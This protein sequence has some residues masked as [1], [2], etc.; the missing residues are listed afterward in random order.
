[1]ISPQKSGLRDSLE[2]CSIDPMDT[3]STL[4]A[5]HTLIT[6]A[7]GV[8]VMDTAA[9][10]RSQYYFTLQGISDLDAQ[11][12]DLICVACRMPLDWWQW[13][14]SRGYSRDTNCDCGEPVTRRF[15]RK[16]PSHQRFAVESPGYFDRVWY[17]ASHNRNWI[18][19]VQGAED[20]ELLVHAGSKLAALSRADDLGRGHLFG[21]RKPIY[22]HSF[23]LSDPSAIST[24][25]YDDLMDEWPVRLDDE[26]PMPLCPI[27]DEEERSDS[28]SWQPL[29]YGVQGAP[30][31][32]RYEIPGEISLILHAGLIN[33]DS[34]ET[35]TLV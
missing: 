11:A 6:G 25:I 30:Y 17:H 18:E 4:E 20:G 21:D 24:T 19:D 15:G 2:L 33:R 12:L 1:M 31:Y 9:V 10:R 27:E 29:D 14:Q 3:T 32:N 8:G 5:P 35:V 23:L 34:V 16:L 13:F 22:L 7:P 28:Y 26:D